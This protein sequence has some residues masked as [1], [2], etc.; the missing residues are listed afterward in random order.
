MAVVAAGLF[1]VLTAAP[2]AGWAQEHDEAMAGE[3]H[4]PGMDLGEG[5]KEELEKALA[6]IKKHNP[7]MHQK[8]VQMRK[9][10]PK[11]FRERVR[12]M[13]PML[14]D[15]KQR[16][17]FLKNAASEHKTQE[18]IMQYRKSEDDAQKESLKKEMRAAL[19]VQ[20]DARLAKQEMHLKKM[21]EDI[22]KLRE[23]I[24]KRRNLKKKIVD[25]HLN[26]ITGDEES[27][28]WR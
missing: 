15:P 24:T 9:R 12:H 2:Q 3:R 14:R 17:M 4:D 10:N 18:L 1:A 8:L 21:E 5:Q 25:R 11:E 6:E 26:E 23:R 19:A 13:A 20:F 22:A 28:E 16:E 27:W 7:K